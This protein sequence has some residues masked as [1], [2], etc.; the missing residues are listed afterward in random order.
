MRIEPHG[1]G[2]LVRVLETGNRTRGGLHIP[3]MAT[4]GTPWLRGEVTGVGEGHYTSQGVLVP[5][6]SKVGDVVIFWRNAKEQ[7]VVPEDDGELLFIRAGHVMG[8]V[9]DL[10][11]VTSIQSIDGRNL[12]LSS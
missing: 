9:R 10:D 1:D 8:F 2:I 3:Q 11:K 6:R 7:I 5:Q 4:D 12:V